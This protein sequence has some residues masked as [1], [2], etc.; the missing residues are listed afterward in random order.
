AIGIALIPQLVPYR[1]LSAVGE[2]L[3]T[4]RVL[5]GLGGGVVVLVISA[6]LARVADLSLPIVVVRTAW[7]LVVSLVPVSL[8]LALLRARLYDRAALIRR[9]LIYGLLSVGLSLAYF[10]GMGGLPALFGPVLSG[11]LR[12]PRPKVSSG[13]LRA[14]EPVASLF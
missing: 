5:A 11:A 12:A 9:A 6:W 14:I 8:G 4:A 1:D 2:R 13:D 3:R 10:A 7:Y